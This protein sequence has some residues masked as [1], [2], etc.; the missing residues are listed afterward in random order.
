GILFWAVRQQLDELQSQALAERNAT[1]GRRRARVLV[2]TLWR[3][4]GQPLLIRPHGGGNAQWRWIVTCPAGTFELGLGELNGIC[5]RVRL[6]SEVLWRFGYRQAWT[7]VRTLLERWA[8]TD[9]GQEVSDATAVE[10]PRA[11]TY[12]MSELHLCADVVGLAVDT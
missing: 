1:R 8:N 4:A 12:Q 11:L 10:A 2:E 3:L 9:P 7:K 6:S 5:C